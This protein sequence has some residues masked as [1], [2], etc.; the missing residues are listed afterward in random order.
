VRDQQDGTPR[1]QRPD[2]LEEVLLGP[3]V[4]RGRRLVEDDERRLAEERP[5]Q[6][7]PLPLAHGQVGAAA[8][9][10]TEHR[11]VPVGKLLDEPVGAGLG[12]GGP[13]A[14]LVVDRLHPAE[15][16]V[17]RG[18]Q[19]EPLEVLEDHRNLPA[20]RVGVH[21]GHVQPVPA[22]LAAIRAV[23]AGQQL[24]QRG[25]ARP[26]LA[27]EGDDLSGRHLQRHAGQRGLVAGRVRERHVRDGHPAK[28]G[29]RRA[30]R[31]G[32]LELGQHGGEY[33]VVVEVAARLGQRP[34]RPAGLREPPADE[35]DRGDRDAGR[36]Q[37]HRATQRQPGHQE[38][39]RQQ[40]RAHHEVRAD[41]E[42]DLL[43]RNPAQLG[44]AFGVQPVVAVPQVGG[45]AERADLLGG[46]PVLQQARE[47]AALP[48]PR[49]HLPEELV[50]RRAAPGRRERRRD[51][52]EREQRDQDGGHR[53]EPDHA[54]G[55]AHD[56]LH[57]AG[58]AEDHVQ[59]LVPA[60]PDA[61]DPVV[62]RRGVKRGEVDRG[63]HV[64]HAALDVPGHEV[65]EDLLPLA[66]QR[67]RRELEG[68]DAGHRQGPGQHGGQ[69]RALAH[70]AQQGVQGGASE[71][72]QA[73]HA[74]AADHQQAGGGDEVAPARGPRDLDGVP[75]Q[76]GQAAHGQPGRR[77]L[78][79]E[80]EHNHVASVA[81][82]NQRGRGARET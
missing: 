56:G 27:D 45:K 13:D 59:R 49:G 79:V 28:A 48:V 63:G 14:G 11:G 46:D 20:Q 78:I 6:C 43:A 40:H 9:L 60:G 51:Q 70:R 34:D 73:D 21:G 65:A 66:L 76:A 37:R 57:E 64:E 2:P 61:L 5:S 24:G 17:V 42:D 77:P 67:A 72:Q 1:Q 80:V 58:Q 29:G 68:G 32:L 26:V 62:E 50:E 54:G 36:G 44:D 39:G 35:R 71:Q 8:E 7:H 15:R 74:D 23:E 81:R 33:H 10:G 41:R 18:G 47:V 52:H 3:R 12:G 69:R 31:P 22:D 82:L 16:D 4:E 19:V 55:D 38:Q 75:Q 30:A 25:L 53:D